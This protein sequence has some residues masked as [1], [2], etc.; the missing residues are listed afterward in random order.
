MQDQLPEGDG[1]AAKYPGD[2]GIEAD[3]QVVFADG[4]EGFEDDAIATDRSPQK[5]M[6]WDM[7]WHNVGITREPANVHS[8]KQAVEIL[9]KGTDRFLLHVMEAHNGRG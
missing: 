8:G 2:V 9:H 3:P 5:G 1:I 6:K 7:A 4:F